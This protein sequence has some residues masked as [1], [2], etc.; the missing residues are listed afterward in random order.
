MIKSVSLVTHV[1]C[2]GMYRVDVSQPLE[3][4]KDVVGLEVQKL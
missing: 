1:Q 4:K 3:I 2:S